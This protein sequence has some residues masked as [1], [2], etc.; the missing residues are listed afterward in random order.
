MAMRKEDK[1]KIGRYAAR[2]LSETNF[3][4]EDLEALPDLPQEIIIE[5][6]SR[7]PVRS[8][9]KFRC[10]SKSWSSIISSPSFIKTHLKISSNSRKYANKSLVF[11]HTNSPSKLYTCYLYSIL[12]ENSTANTMEIDPPLRMQG[13]Q[14]SFVGCCNGLVCILNSRDILVLWNPSTRKSK[15]LPYSP[16]HGNH[17]Y[18]A[19]GFGYDESHDDYKVV[20]ICNICYQPFSFETPVNVY[21]LVTNSWRRIQ[22][23]LGPFVS[24]RSCVFMNNALHWPVARSNHDK[25]TRSILSFNMAEETYQ[26][27]PVFK[28]ENRYFGWSIGILEEC[29]VTCEYC[30]FWTEVW[31]L[32]EYGVKESWTKLFT[33]PLSFEDTILPLL[34]IENSG[35]VV[36]CGLGIM[37]YNS[38]DKSAKHWELPALGNSLKTA[39]ATYIESL[40]SPDTEDE[41]GA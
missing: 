7:L 35:I 28:L 41:L 33:I 37:L 38:Q 5:I 3:Y 24:P 14:L 21:S 4:Q 8:L 40:V 27:I 9:V 26:Q 30:E 19:Y 18:F 1:M 36:K 13:H 10:V 34:V 16:N 12:S 6:L 11:G 20:E 31:A 39:A 15:Q 2:P 22:D 32:K 29:L 23:Y 17:G 25:V